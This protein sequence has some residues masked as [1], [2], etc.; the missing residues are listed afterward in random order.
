MVHV[1]DLDWDDGKKALQNYNKNDTVKVKLLTVESD[2][3]RIS[4]GIKQMQEN[5][6]AELSK[7]FKK[8]DVVTGIVVKVDDKGVDVMI[9]DSIPGFIRRSDLSK[10]RAEQRSD[11]F[12]EGEKLDAQI[13]S[14][15]K[16]TGRV[17]LSIK[18]HEVEEQK[19]AM[20]IYGS[21]DSGAVL[22]DILGDALKE[23][24]NKK[25]A[26]KEPAKKKAA[27]PAKEKK[28]K[29]A[30]PKADAPEGGAPEGDA[31]EADAPETDA[32]EADAPEGDAPESGAKN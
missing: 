21:S 29:E 25:K 2:K 18:I 6:S 12:A 27:T 30:A 11:R 9:D 22:G 24:D 23:R 14:V 3:E 13:V 17:N 20:E 32:P 5:K 4:L 16:K 7:K 15:D 19:K 1:T 31:P 8:G 10:D 28:S 26:E